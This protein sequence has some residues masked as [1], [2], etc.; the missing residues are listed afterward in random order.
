MGEHR[1][2]NGKMTAFDSDIRVP[3]IAVGPGVPAGSSI[4]ELTANIDIAPTFMR[5]AGQAPPRRVDGH[6]LAALLHGERPA[7]WR[8]AVLIEH[9]GPY[10]SL[11]DPDRQAASSGNPPSYEAVRTVN[12]TYVS[13]ETGEREYYDVRKDP[14]QLENVWK[15]LDPGEQAGLETTLRR[16]RNCHDTRA[17]WRASMR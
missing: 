14:Y 16:L 15:E 4:E 5:L 13:Y 11:D 12:G 17:C 8:D 1:L 2:L 6:G 10:Y 9:H 7:V 3:L